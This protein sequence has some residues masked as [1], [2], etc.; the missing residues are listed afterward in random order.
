MGEFDDRALAHAVDQ[1]IAL[2]VH[3]NA[4]ADFVAPVIVVGD[5]A[6]AGFDA[7]GDDRHALV[8]LA[9]ALAVGQRAAVGAAADAPAGAVGIVVAHFAVGGVVVDHRIHVAGADGE[10]QPR[11]AE[12]A[13]R[14]ARM[15]IGLAEDGDAEA[16]VFQQAAEQRHGETGMIDVGIAGDEDDV[17]A[18]QPRSS[19]SARDM[20]S[21]GEVS[22]VQVF[23]CAEWVKCGGRRASRRGRC[24]GPARGRI[25]RCAGHR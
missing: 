3:Q 16:F 6:E 23:G 7:A 5:A 9:G 22:G 12:G 24:R 8:R 17:D 20:G 1:Q 2:G 15:P 10:E 18:S 4:A 11:L 14:L 19:I 13:P 21:G 25:R